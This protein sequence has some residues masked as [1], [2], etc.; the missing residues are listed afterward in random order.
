MWLRTLIL[1]TLAISAFGQAMLNR[2]GERIVD[3]V[4]EIS[5]PIQDA[6][7]N[8]KADIVLIIDGSRSIHP[9]DFIEQIKF[10]KRFVDHFIIGNNGMRFGVVTF[11]DKVIMDNTFGL[12]QYTSNV[13]LKDRLSSIDYRPRD[14]TS[15]QT[16]LAIK[17]ARETLFTEARLDTK[18]IAFVITDGNSRNATETA[19]E[20]MKMRNEEIVILAIGVGKDVSE[21]ELHTITG[22]N[23]YVFMIDEYSL[24]K[25]L[26]SKLSE[27]SCKHK[28][29]G[30]SEDVDINFV[31]D[32]SRM[33][34]NE[35][36]TVTTFITESIADGKFSGKNVR[37]G[38]IP[39]KCQGLKGFYLDTYQS[40]YTARKHFNN[41][42]RASI[43]SLLEESLKE[44]FTCPYGGR[45]EARK[46][47][48]IFLKGKLIDQ[49]RLKKNVQS[50]RK[51]GIEVF[52]IKM[53][54]LDSEMTLT[55]I[56]GRRNIL[57][58]TKIKSMEEVRHELVNR[59]CK[60]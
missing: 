43:A 55:R 53:E 7:S 25:E 41:L 35:T 15:T 59:I 9:S 57:D 37:I 12:T 40:K 30:C 32:P 8:S 52:G 46:V 42:Q 54:N 36:R 56:F 44:Y 1:L 21:E 26:E 29:E 18:K 5:Q 24:L 49:D 20:A 60:W 50:L 16:G 14:G 22:R 39:G 3:T 45:K 58:A 2:N 23:D 31:F 48:V 11:G 13:E 51:S 34:Y 4:R 19:E 17:Y 47:A 27:I 28:N 6:C 33:S 38:T 10:L